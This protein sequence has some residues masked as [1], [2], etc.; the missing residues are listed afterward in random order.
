MKDDKLFTVEGVLEESKR[1]LQYVGYQPQPTPAVPVPADFY[2][3][4]QAEATTYQ[5]VGVVRE[6]VDE[7]I[8]ALA[9]LT[10][11]KTSLG[12]AAD[13]VVVLPPVKE[14]LMIELLISERG[15]W[16]YEI[17]QQQF[18]IWLCNPELQTTTCLIGSPRDKAFSDYFAGSSVLNFEQYLNMRF[19]R[20]GLLEEDL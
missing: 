10:T 1:F 18:M 20:E 14:Y 17:K 19:W 6:Q 13:Y 8:D 9:A 5:I 12:E 11:I 7:I 4:R 15:R 3:T 16:F 2:V